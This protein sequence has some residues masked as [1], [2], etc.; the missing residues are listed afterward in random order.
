MIARVLPKEEWHRLGDLP[1]SELF[2][3]VRPEDIR[4]IVVEAEGAIVGTWTLLRM[5]HLEGIWVDE[6]HRNA[7]VVRSLMRTAF[8]E[9]DEWANGWVLTGANTDAVRGILARLQATKV[10]MDTYMLGLKGN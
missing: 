1:I 7:G 5:T 9:A 6:K 8:R 3:F 4:V 10:D 2:P